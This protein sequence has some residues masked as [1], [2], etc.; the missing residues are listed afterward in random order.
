MDRNAKIEKPI[1]ISG[2]RKQEIEKRTEG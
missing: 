1:A 2:R